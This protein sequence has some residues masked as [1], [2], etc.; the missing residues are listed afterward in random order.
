MGAQDSTFTWCALGTYSRALNMLTESTDVIRYITFC[1]RACSLSYLR[2]G[3]VVTPFSPHWNS[4]DWGVGKA[5]ISMNQSMLATLC[6]VSTSRWTVCYSSD[7]SRDSGMAISWVGKVVGLHGSIFRMI[8][9]LSACLLSLR[10]AWDAIGSHFCQSEV[11]FHCQGGLVGRV[12]M[13]GFF[14]FFFFS[15]VTPHV[16]LCYCRGVP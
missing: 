14:F 8:T 12:C 9:T 10:V 15:H 1:Q 3:V 11:V 4:W 6:E 13:L 7:T 2:S 5:A 16:A